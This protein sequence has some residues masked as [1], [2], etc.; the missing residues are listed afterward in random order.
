MTS[1]K[2]VQVLRVEDFRVESG[3]EAQPSARGSAQARNVVRVWLL[4]QPAMA[5]GRVTNAFLEARSD[6]A[7]PDVPRYDF[8]AKRIVIPYT[9]AAIAPVVS[10]LLDGIQVYCQYREFEGGAIYADV[11][12]P[13]VQQ[14]NAGAGDLHWV[15]SG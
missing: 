10:M 12:R 11:H 7:Q 15:P 13:S 5:H 2:F 3:A 6:W 8:T 14:T 1:S 9:L 4:G